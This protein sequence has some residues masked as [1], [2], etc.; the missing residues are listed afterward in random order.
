[1]KQSDVERAARRALREVDRPGVRLRFVAATER[2]GV[3]RV[4]LWTDGLGPNLTVDL[5]AAASL[6]EA[7]DI[8][9]DSIR[10]A[11]GS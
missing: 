7:V 8:V 4:G 5:G 11:L 3:F 2:A 6:S 1:M 9:A 10:D